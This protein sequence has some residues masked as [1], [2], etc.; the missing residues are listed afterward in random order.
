MQ[1]RHRVA[2]LAFDGI[3]PFHLAVPSAVFASGGGSAPVTGYEVT[4]CAERPGAVPTAGGYAVVVEHGLE[5]FAAADT[6]VVPSWDTA[7]EPSDV[8]LDAV[9]TAHARG[10]RVVGLC[11]GAF[12][13]AASGVAD[14]RE[15]A[16]HWHA[17]D[18]L[19]RRYPAVAVRDDVLWCDDGDVVTSAGV[20][21]AL[22]CCL[23]L[24]RRDLG[25][26]LAARVARSLVLAP[27]RDG[28]QGQFIPAPVAEHAGDDALDRALAWA[29]Q[30]LDEPVDL[31]A[32]AG[33]AHL[34]RRT[35]T[36][37][38]RERTGT[39]P[40]RWLLTQRLARARVLLET[41]DLG[42]EE[43]ARRSGF[44]TAVTLRQHFATHL[45]T[46]PRRH[47]Q[48]FRAEPAAGA[49]VDVGGPA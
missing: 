25:A 19:R 37:Q 44:G 30:H 13:V 6:V 36:R 39:S 40:G 18:R 20:A 7:V 33:A 31:D 10:A 28:N 5:A 27:H 32:W 45:A 43:V 41:T 46:S 24:V 35:F 3:S 21:S 26:D 16:T 42:V 8:L 14:G 9:R 1:P 4:V 23:H 11:L 48:A 34:A 15:V 47:R 2:V 49:A 38:F 17:A 22:D 12:V 29:E